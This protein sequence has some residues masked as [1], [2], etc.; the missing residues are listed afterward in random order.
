[1]AKRLTVLDFFKKYPDEDTCLEHIM[2]VRYG[3]HSECP[4]CHKATTFYRIKKRPAYACEFCG[5]HISPMAGTPFENTRTPLQMWFYAIYLFTTTKHGVP[6]KEL[7]RQLGVTYKTAWRMGHEIRKYMA[8]VGGDD[9]LGG[10]VEADET[11]VGGKPR[12][13]G[14]SRGGRSADGKTIIFGMVERGG[15]LIAKV[16]QRTNRATIEP[17]I[18]QH[19]AKGSVMS[20]DEWVA[21]DR[22][23]NMGFVHGRVNHG[24]GEWVRGRCHTNTIEGFWSHFKC[25]VKGTHRSVSPQHMQKYLGEFEFRFNHRDLT[26][27]RMLDRLL[28]AF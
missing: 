19:V 16:V 5:H 1:V 7:Q 4:K 21:Y 12:Y 25:A 17:I 24:T 23:N 2:E 14:A 11:Y 9:G 22:L 15:D 20:T 27:D 8:E 13:R 3:K 6:A 18:E 10:H 26:S 28:K